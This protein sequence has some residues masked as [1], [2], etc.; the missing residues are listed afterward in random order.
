[1]TLEP[2]AAAILTHW[3]NR[4]T[5]AMRNV[6]AET[7][8]IAMQS[9]QV[10]DD[11]FRYLSF[12][13]TQLQVTPLIQSVLADKERALTQNCDKL[14]KRVEDTRVMLVELQRTLQTLILLADIKTMQEE[15]RGYV[16]VQVEEKKV[17]LDRLQAEI[18]RLENSVSQRLVDLKERL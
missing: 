9:P 11:A 1:M 2:Y 5:E 17:R 10:R 8:E 3:Q 18:Q 14:Q 7:I 4:D 16:Q 13:A 6:I 12:W 15:Q